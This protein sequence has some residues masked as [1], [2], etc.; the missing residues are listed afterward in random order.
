MP[1][2]AMEVELSSSIS[3]CR[4]SSIGVRV[5]TAIELDVCVAP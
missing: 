3:V 1:T 2:G 4:S 5:A